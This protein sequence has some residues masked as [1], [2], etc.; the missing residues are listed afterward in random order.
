[1]STRPSPFEADA[2]RDQSGFSLIEAL[3]ALAILAIAAVG[4]VRA[5]ESHIDSTRAMESR[6]IAMWV[7]EN[8]LAELEV[9]PG[10][11][12]PREVAMLGRQWRVDVDR[13][14]T[15]DPEIERVRIEVSEPGGASALAALDGFLDGRRG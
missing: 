4:L 15:E 5:T 14:G 3:V 11:D 1:M 13:R 12:G 8:R 9:E 7:A 2:P 10:A 6:A